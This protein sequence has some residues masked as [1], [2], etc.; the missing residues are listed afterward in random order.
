[1][2]TILRG[3]K[4]T[5]LKW[6][7]VTGYKQGE[8]SQGRHWSVE[9]KTPRLVITIVNDHRDY[10]GWWCLYC[11]PHYYLEKSRNRL[12]DGST[13]PIPF[14][15]AEPFSRAKTLKGAQRAALTRVKDIIFYECNVLRGDLLILENLY[16]R[17]D[18]PVEL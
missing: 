8:P 15:E 5:S 3:E 14:C 4:N 7:D 2:K 16:D 13:K 6:R 10:K 11:S 9:T 1:M 17:L 18:V 12:D